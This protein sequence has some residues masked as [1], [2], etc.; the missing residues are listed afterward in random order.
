VIEVFINECHSQLQVYLLLLVDEASD[1]MEYSDP[2]EYSPFP[3]TRKMA[4]IHNS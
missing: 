4:L 2:M 1:S 3:E